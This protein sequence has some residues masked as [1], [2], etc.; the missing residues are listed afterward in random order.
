[1]SITFFKPR[2]YSHHRCR[3]ELYRS[4][5]LELNAS[6]ERGIK[7]VR[8]KVK[9]FASTQATEVHGYVSVP[10][11]SLLL[12][13][14]WLSFFFFSLA[15]YLSL[16]TYGLF[17]L[18]V[19]LCHLLSVSRLFLSLNSKLQTSL[20]SLRFSFPPL[21]NLSNSHDSTGFPCPPYKIIILDEADSMTADA[22]AALRR[23]M[24]DHSRSTRF[25]IICNYIS[26]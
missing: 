3:P 18:A 7:V 26:R 21:F 4:R 16:C 14:F 6:D 8:E 17:G 2:R 1:M 11:F 15:V 22:Q 10:P 19:S 25:C 24:E 20:V 9:S 13:L 5:V 23:T 12:S